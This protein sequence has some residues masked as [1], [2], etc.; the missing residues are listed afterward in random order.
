MIT[1]IKLSLYVGLAAVA[2]Y[3]IRKWFD[4]GVCTSKARL[5]GKTVVITGG[6]TGI[7][8]ETAIDMARRGAK[9]IIGCRNQQRGEKAVGEIQ[10]KSGSKNVHLRSLDLASFAS[11]RAFAEGV[12]RSESRLDILINN[13]GI[14][15]CP[16]AKTEDGFQTQFGVN[17]LGHFLLTNLLVDLIEK[18]APSRIVIVSSLA[19]RFLT[20]VNFDKVNDESSYDPMNAYSESKLANVLFANELSKR[21]KNKNVSVFS[22]HPGVVTTELG[23]Y[24]SFMNH[25]IVKLLLVPV[26]KLIYKDSQQGA[27]TS[28]CCAVEEGLEKLT[29]E[30]F[31]DCAVAT[32][33]AFAQDEQLAKKLWQLSMQW[34]KL[35]KQQ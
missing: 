29:G 10:E 7:G 5:D 32:K 11:I 2:L 26:R 8:K 12:L 4:G 18:S 13:A 23:R 17:H 33:S 30:Y 22:L 3:G 14:M 31:A 24:S 15:A 25:P 21:L 6:N 16:F 20:S 28:I 19:H 1:F 27:Q 35:E 34:T 9:V